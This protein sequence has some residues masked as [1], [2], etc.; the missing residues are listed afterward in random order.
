[1]MPKKGKNYWRTKAQQL[2]DKRK[3]PGTLFGEKARRK[4]A[5]LQRKWMR[6]TLKPWVGKSSERKD[7][8]ENPSR[9]TLNPV[10]TPLDVAHHEYE[11]ETAMP[12][13]FPYTRGIYP[14][15]YR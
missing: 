9:I 14:N 4:V 3:K 1:M 5:L 11:K 7:H 8:F 6:N 12:G 2:S 13:E 10:Y 15:M